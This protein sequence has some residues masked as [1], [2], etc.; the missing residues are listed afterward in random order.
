MLTVLVGG[1]AIA[2]VFEL[3]A[4]HGFEAGGTVQHGRHRCCG[5]R[6]GRHCRY[7][8]LN[9]WFRAAALAAAAP[10]DT[11]AAPAA[12]VSS[13]AQTV[14]LGPRINAPVCGHRRFCDSG[15]RLGAGRVRAGEKVERGQEHECAR[16]ARAGMCCWRARRRDAADETRRRPRRSTKAQAALDGRTCAALVVP[17]RSSAQRE[18][19]AG[20]AV[21]RRMV[22]SSGRSDVGRC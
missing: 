7:T 21:P 8:W 15:D 16:G 11:A 5:G 2:H 13:A 6:G 22:A 4:V 1:V 3:S 12:R 9:A 14:G 19:R 18:W 20:I 10:A 17:E